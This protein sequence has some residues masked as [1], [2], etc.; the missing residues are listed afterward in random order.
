M[1]PNVI[2]YRV[3]VNVHP[4]GLEPAVMYRVRTVTMDR[5]AVKFANVKIMPDVARMTAIAFV[6]PVGWE[7]TVKMVKISGFFWSKLSKLFHFFLLTV[8]PE[9]FYGQHC[10]DFCSCS[11]PQFVCHVA[12]GCICRQGF[13]G[14]D[15]LTPS[16]SAQEQ[17][18]PNSAGIAWGIVVALVLIGVI[19]AVLLYY[20]RKVRDLKTIVADVE[21]H[22]NPQLQPDRHHFDNPVYAFQ[23]GSA[24]DN[25]HLLNNL[26][27]AKPTNLERYKLGLAAVP[28]DTDS[29]AS[30]RGERQQQQQKKKPF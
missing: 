8:C 26:R 2:T 3:S 9:G 24:G 22:A 4:V 13:M 6:I 20:R 29:N 16:R 27:P 10:M 11:S 14:T 12:Y 25:T 15:C 19:V 5:I 7:H 17:E 1:V 18:Q 28:T 23:N 21:Y 30:S